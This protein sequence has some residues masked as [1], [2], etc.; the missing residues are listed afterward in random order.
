MFSGRKKPISKQK[1]PGKKLQKKRRPA[2]YGDSGMTL[3]NV[4]G[5]KLEQP[6]AMPPATNLVQTLESSRPQ[7]ARNASKRS[8]IFGLTPVL[9]HFGYEVELSFLTPLAQEVQHRLQQVTGIGIYK[10][11]DGPGIEIL[12]MQ[13][14]GSARALAAVR[15][16]TRDFPTDQRILLCRELKSLLTAEQLT[17]LKRALYTVEQIH[18]EDIDDRIATPRSAITAPLK[19]IVRPSPARRVAISEPA[20]PKSSRVLVDNHRFSRGA[21][22]NVE[23]AGGR[24]EQGDISVRTDICVQ[25]R[26]RLSVPERSTVV[27]VES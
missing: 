1:S 13:D 16:L 24:R 7:L 25:D 21:E 2:V 8:S 18:C 5:I 27:K 20:R 6:R 14:M 9:D 17:V 12:V 22:Q 11:G 10:P 4:G 23:R 3:A 19:A 15:Y 26:A